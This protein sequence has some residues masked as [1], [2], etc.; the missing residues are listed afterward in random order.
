MNQG[1]QPEGGSNSEFED[2]LK[3]KGEEAYGFNDISGKIDIHQIQCK[4]VPA[5]VTAFRSHRVHVDNTGEEDD[6]T[7]F[8]TRAKLY[9]QDENFAYKERGT[10]LLKINV[11][12]NDGEGARIGMK[13]HRRL[14]LLNYIV[15]SQ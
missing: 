2:I 6:L 4:C 13:H 5:P 10:G 1:I 11:R 3:A 12:R 15:R 7:I 9:T 8:Q 14:D